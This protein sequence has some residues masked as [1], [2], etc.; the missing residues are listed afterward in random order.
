MDD[1]PTAKPHH[2]PHQCVV[3]G[4]HS[5]R[6]PYCSRDCRIK[7]GEP[8]YSFPVADIAPEAEGREVVWTD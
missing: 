8:G 1:R 2:K 4:E 5:K 7:A 6:F 3:C